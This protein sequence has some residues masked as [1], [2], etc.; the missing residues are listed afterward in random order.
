MT[1]DTYQ[2]QRLTQPLQVDAKWE[3]YPWVE[4]PALK[5]AHHMG[6]HPDHFPHVQVKLAYDEAALYAIFQVADRYVRA[7]TQNYQDAVFYDSCVEFFFTPGDDEAL[8]YFN[9]EMNCGGTA[10]FHHQTGRRENDVAVSATD[11]EK[12][13]LAH[14]LP[15]IVDPEIEENV[16]WVVEY[17]LPFEIL[18]HYTPVVQPKQGVTWKVNFY[19]CADGSSHPHWLSWSP[20]NAPEPDFHR[21]EFFGILRFD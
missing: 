5:L 14:T 7:L 11:F 4:V 17:Y 18:T 8:G 1:V 6:K 2:V 20:V 3:K 12:V 9:L 10:L 21:P 19:K 15:K 16:N 13:R